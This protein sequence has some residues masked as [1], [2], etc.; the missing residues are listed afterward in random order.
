MSGAA[1]A[2]RDASRYR[3]GTDALPLS[4][5]GTTVLTHE[6]RIAWLRLIRSE[7]V[8]P[9]TFRELVNQF[10][11]AGQALAALPTLSRRGGRKQALRICRRDEAE[12]ELDTID[13]LDAHLVAIGEPGY[14]AW[15]AR[16]EA[17]P[18]LLCIKGRPDIV[19][20]PII[21]IVGSR[22]GS[23]AGLQIAR[24]L[25]ADLGACGFTI[26]SGLARG[27]DA[28]VHRA[29]LATGTVAV[30]A[31]GVDIVYPPEHADL[32]RQIAREGLLI[33]ERP[34]GLDPRAQDFPRRNRLISGVAAGLIVVEAARRSGS[35]ITARFAAEQ[36]RE[37][38]AVPGNP[39]DP[40]AEGTN[41]LLKNGATLVTDADDVTSALAATLSG[42]TLAMT[43]G[44]VREADN[45]LLMGSS[46]VFRGDVGGRE[47]NGEISAGGGTYGADS[48]AESADAPTSADVRDSIVRSL[49]PAP[50][51]L[52]TI[53]RVTGC[54]AR[55]LRVVMLELDLAGRIE[56]HPGNRISLLSP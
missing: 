51:E 56:H 25:A 48:V 9:I 37:V 49:G 8:G 52:D 26:A 32:H 13:R 20:R 36:G 15:L 17:P 6:Q 41:G 11:G 53:A 4:E 12:A 45:S 34:P 27:I 43:P 47:T 29:S 18:P 30:L 21:S 5:G 44:H 38:F 28:S 50:V 1:D 35:L 31:G 40:R 22:N 14:P 7:N 24:K 2:S 10:G 42:R 54:T 23:A 46:R 19:V 55:D 33:C 3:R 39:L 16:I